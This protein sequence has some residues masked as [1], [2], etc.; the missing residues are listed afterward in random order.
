MVSRETFLRCINYLKR[1]A[2]LDNR[3]GDVLREYGD[4]VTDCNIGIPASDGILVEVI[5]ES[6]KLKK[7]AHE[8]TTLSWWVYEADF[9]DNKQFIESFE[10]PYLP[11]DHPY[12]HPRLYTADAL[13]DYLVW[14]SGG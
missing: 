9:G 1:R 10:I 7:D 13:Y 8:Y 5:E 4:I 12:R 2:E 11:D 14:E 3:L 6:F